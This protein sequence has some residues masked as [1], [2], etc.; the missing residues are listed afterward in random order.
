VYE[1]KRAVCGPVVIHLAFGCL[2]TEH[3]KCCV[4]AVVPRFATL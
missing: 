2:L 4:R 3:R 1:A